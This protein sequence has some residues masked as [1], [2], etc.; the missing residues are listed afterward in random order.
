MAG[1]FRNLRKMGELV[2]EYLDFG[3]KELAIMTAKRKQA[4]EDLAK[5]IKVITICLH[6]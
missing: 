6:H 2:Y 5:A 3:N 4:E 1:I